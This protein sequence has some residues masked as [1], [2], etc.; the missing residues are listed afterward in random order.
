[1][2]GID[3]VITLEKDYANVPVF[4]DA[5][6][7]NPVIQRYYNTNLKLKQE[8]PNFL[9]QVREAL[10]QNPTKEFMRQYDNEFGEGASNYLLRMGR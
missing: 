4:S 9:N 1:M 6:Q 8:E 3:G 2:F 10:R 5:F 7:N